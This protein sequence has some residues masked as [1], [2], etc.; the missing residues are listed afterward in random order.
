MRVCATRSMDTQGIPACPEGAR[1]ETTDL[2]GKTYYGLVDNILLS[3]TDS[4]TG[5]PL[6]GNKEWQAISF[7]VG[8]IIMLVVWL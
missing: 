5:S 6:P 2:P 1:E 4:P 8:K 3:H 7:S